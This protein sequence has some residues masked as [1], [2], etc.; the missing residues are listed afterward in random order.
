ML[1]AS[2]TTTATAVPIESRLLAARVD[3]G[4]GQVDVKRA[5]GTHTW[6]SIAIEVDGGRDQS[7]VTT[8]AD[9]TRGRRHGRC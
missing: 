1:F 5:R 3:D 4:Q 6:T 7:L 8:A 2:R 9:R